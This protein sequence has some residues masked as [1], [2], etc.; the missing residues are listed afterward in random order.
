[1]STFFNLTFGNTIQLESDM[2]SIFFIELVPVSLA[3]GG[4]ERHLGGQGGPSERAERGR[5]DVQVRQ[6]GRLDELTHHDRQDDLREVVGQVQH[7]HV[8]P[9]PDV[10]LLSSPIVDLGIGMIFCYLKF[11]AE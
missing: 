6:A 2:F 9:E 11:D 10:L 4:I 5:D 3:I 7:G 8:A 1:M